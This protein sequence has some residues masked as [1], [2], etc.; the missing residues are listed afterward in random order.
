MGLALASGVLAQPAPELDLAKAPLLF[1]RNQEQV[2][3]EVRYLALGLSETVWTTGSEIVFGRESGSISM[4]LVGAEDLR[5]EALK[6]HRHRTDY[7]QGSDPK[8]WVLGVPSYSKIHA[9]EVYPGIAL[10]LYGTADGA[11]E[12]DFAV[13]P[14]ANADS[15][16]LGFGGIESVRI[17]ERG[18]LLLDGPGGLR[19]HRAPIAFQLADNR[20]T[21]VEAAFKIEDY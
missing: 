21:R 15:I 8:K 17:G 18:D 11:L 4:R 2:E 9:E 5:F 10:T 14:G 6:P 3:P 20:R 12:Y 7:Y 13:G 16:R 19:V 1:E